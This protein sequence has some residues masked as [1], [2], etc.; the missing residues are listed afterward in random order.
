MAIVVRFFSVRRGIPMSEK[1]L[2]HADHGEYIRFRDN[3][4]NTNFLRVLLQA[5]AR[6]LRKHHDWHSR[7]NLQHAARGLQPVHAGHL[8]IQDH[9]VGMQI[10]ELFHSG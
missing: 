2:N 5:C 6:V 7:R 1:F 4:P 8:K 9:Y 10:S 3:G